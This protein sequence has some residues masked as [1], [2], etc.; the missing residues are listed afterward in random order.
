MRINLK[1]LPPVE[2]LNSIALKRSEDE[3]EEAS[4]AI[5]K[6]AAG[7]FR[8]CAP[9]CLTGVL[10]GDKW[11]MTRCSARFDS[12]MISALATVVMQTVMPALHGVPA[13]ARTFLKQIIRWSSRFEKYFT[14][15]RSLF[16]V[17]HWVLRQRWD[18]VA[19]LRLRRLSKHSTCNLCPNGM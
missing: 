1:F 18:L 2:Q 16:T 4:L 13:Q 8:H 3:R 14:A 11:R 12:K 10:N 5:W 17:K 19:E 15:E 6:I 7:G 9:Q